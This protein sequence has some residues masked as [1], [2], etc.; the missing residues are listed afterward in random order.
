M[1]DFHYVM[2]SLHLAEFMSHS[3]AVKA[4]GVACSV[5]AFSD[6]LA[7][8]IKIARPGSGVWR[9]LKRPLEPI[10]VTRRFR[11]AERERRL[12][13]AEERSQVVNRATRERILN[14]EFFDAASMVRDLRTGWDGE[15]LSLI[16][17]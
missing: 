15:I 11:T 5:V 17:I 9:I 3:G 7:Y 2:R 8:A 10:P 6:S 14:L 4:L 13:M 1:C 12:R 16:H